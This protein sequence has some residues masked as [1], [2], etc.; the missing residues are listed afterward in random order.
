M[1]ASSV[2]LARTR[3]SNVSRSLLA[4]RISLVQ[5]EQDL[6]RS[7]VLLM[8]IVCLLI[9]GCAGT[10]LG[11]SDAGPTATPSSWESIPLPDGV[12]PDHFIES[13]APFA[14]LAATNGKIY[15]H[16]CFLDVKDWT[17]GEI[18]NGLGGECGSNPPPYGLWYGIWHV[19]FPD[20]LPANKSR[21]YCI[22]PGDT[23]FDE[24]Y[25]IHSV[26]ACLYIISDDG[27]LLIWKTIAWRR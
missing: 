21:T 20:P 16:P 10:S 11:G 9:T 22:V 25:T 15:N 2:T 26:P 3:L 14:Q 24:P 1:C 12:Q 27:Q 19:D 17:A 6:M 13:S 7:V 4:G 5:K 23:Y 18:K 8:G